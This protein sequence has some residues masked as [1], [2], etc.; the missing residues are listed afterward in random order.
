MLGR[1]EDALHRRGELIDTGIL[2]L[3]GNFASRTFDFAQD[4]KFQIVAGDNFS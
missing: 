3:R 2:R 4:D 1:R